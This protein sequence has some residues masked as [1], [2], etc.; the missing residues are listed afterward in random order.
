MS[1]VGQGIGY[2][3]QAGTQSYGAARDRARADRAQALQKQLGKARIDLM[4]AQEGE[5]RAKTERENARRMEEAAAA[6]QALIIQKAQ[7]QMALVDVN[8]YAARIKLQ[9]EMEL[10]RKRKLEHENTAKAIKNQEEEERLR[11]LTEKPV[12]FGFSVGEYVAPEVV[13]P[14]QMERR[15]AAETEQAEAQAAGTGATA[16]L[17][18]F[19]LEQKQRQD[20]I[21]VILEQAA[22]L[23]AQG[24]VDAAKVLRDEAEALEKAR[25]EAQKKQYAAEKKQAEAVEKT[26]VPAAEAGVGKTVAET[27]EIAA[28]TGLIGA[29]AAET[30]ALAPLR[31]LLLGGQVR[32][33]QLDNQIKKVAAAS[34]PFF[35]RIERRMRVAGLGQELQKLQEA[36][37]SW[38]VRMAQMQANRDKAIAEAGKTSTEARFW[39]KRMEA[40]LGHME[41]LTAN[42]A[43]K[44][45]IDEQTLNYLIDT[46]NYRVRMDELKVLDAEK[47]LDLKDLEFVGKTLENQMRQLDVEIKEASQ[48][49]NLSIARARAK[50]MK[51]NA[52]KMAGLEVQQ[53]IAKLQ[54]AV[55]AAKLN[56]E[57]SKGKLKKAPEVAEAWANLKIAQAKYEDARQRDATADAAIKETEEYKDARMGEL[58]SQIEKFENSRL[59][60]LQKRKKIKEFVQ[61]EYDMLL[62]RKELNVAS[63][64]EKREGIQNDL[65]RLGLEG[66]RVALAEL[67]REDYV[68]FRARELEIMTADK[69][70][71]HV[72]RILGLLSAEREG[73]RNRTN[74]VKLAQIREKGADSR[75]DK[76][77]GFRKSEGALE[78]GSRESIAAANRA[79]QESMQA[80][81]HTHASSMALLDIYAQNL[82]Q[83]KQAS[84]SIYR[85]LIRNNNTLQIERM[86][87]FH[88]EMTQ[89][90]EA[91][92]NV[93]GLLMRRQE[94]GLPVDDNMMSLVSMMGAAYEPTAMG[95]AGGDGASEKA[96]NFKAQLAD[97]HKFLDSTKG[98]N[99]PFD[100]AMTGE[101]IRML[102]EGFDKAFPNMPPDAKKMLR[103]VLEGKSIPIEPPQV[104]DEKG[105]KGQM[106]P[107]KAAVDRHKQVWNNLFEFGRKSMGSGDL[108][109]SSGR[110]AVLYGSTVYSSSNRAAQKLTPAM[111]GNRGQR[112]LQSIR[113]GDPGAIR[114]SA[115][116]IVS[117]ANGS[118]GFPDWGYYLPEGSA[119]PVF[120]ETPMPRDLVSRYKEGGFFMDAKGA[121]SK[122]SEPGGSRFRN[123]VKKAIDIGVLGADETPILVAD[124]GGEYKDLHP[125][126]TIE[127]MY[128]N[129]GPYMRDNPKFMHDA[130]ALAAKD[131]VIPRDISGDIPGFTVRAILHWMSKN[132]DNDKWAN[133]AIGG[134]PNEYWKRSA[135]EI[136]INVKMRGRKR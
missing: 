114:E 36:K 85:D 8:D 52:T 103:G 118:E 30:R 34:A 70:A 126:V 55:E 46:H 112:L 121:F 2:G 15:L 54:D 136:G 29:Q 27:N 124:G 90:K 39:Q 63:T 10:A 98:S 57:L 94:E 135:D 79:S 59:T 104:G 115:G 61:L 102:F 93:V 48:P 64:E 71:G 131:N 11:I 43:T 68:K 91:F 83:N 77:I 28:R 73:E 130:I 132:A 133:V 35:D 32:S 37:A 62:S 50:A 76:E 51:L 40:E 23:E 111:R 31:A 17:S 99:S 13:L 41:Q 82:R 81:S 24:N 67:S 16:G 6:E 20:K 22:L 9:R 100:A 25:V 69:A 89:S 78:R 49:G 117:A 129:M 116:S 42:L 26:A 72:V 96:R 60:E 12:D 119:Q 47:G 1:G 80:S 97:F 66:R 7:A 108:S 44:G 86:K 84:V 109:R 33:L 14:S 92:G 113:N 125:I 88:E 58:L 3:L 45:Q 120:I 74:A 18:A 110:A 127:S 21:Q 65:A 101:K 87:Q 106:D 134:G 95:H 56:T 123:V 19:E 107:Q 105:G 5:T 122:S 4:D 75:T 53:A 38:P 128:Q